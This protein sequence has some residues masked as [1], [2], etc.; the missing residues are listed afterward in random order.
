M[1]YEKKTYNAAEYKDQIKQEEHKI[2]RNRNAEITNLSV[3]C[4]I[5]L[6]LGKTGKNF[7]NQLNTKR[8]IKIEKK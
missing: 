3:F 4:V 6:F 7:L 2:L 8:D 5:E 1:G